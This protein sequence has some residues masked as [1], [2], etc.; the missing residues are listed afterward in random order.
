MKIHELVLNAK[1]LK[2]EKL[3]DSTLPYIF[4]KFNRRRAL[5]PKRYSTEKK[6]YKKCAI[7]DLQGERERE[8][9]S[10]WAYLRQQ[11]PT[12]KARMFI[13]QPTYGTAQK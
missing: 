8:G 11:D 7:F 4:N 13:L 2:Q 3:I 5:I 9:D 10:D 1:A 12:F 6:R